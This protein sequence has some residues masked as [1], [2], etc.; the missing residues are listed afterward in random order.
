LLAVAI[1][2][3]DGVFAKQ[4]DLGRPDDTVTLSLFKD[5]NHWTVWMDDADA[6][7]LHASAACRSGEVSNAI[8]GVIDSLLKS[9]RATIDQPDTKALAGPAHEREDRE[10]RMLKAL[11]ANIR[12]EHTKRSVE[13]LT[14]G[15]GTL[16]EAG[17]FIKAE[18]DEEKSRD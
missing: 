7:A 17:S 4:Y 10:Y 8:S 12:V 1:N 3:E 5:V 16:A 13:L 15:F 2:N 18:A 11:L 6:I 14:D 9:A